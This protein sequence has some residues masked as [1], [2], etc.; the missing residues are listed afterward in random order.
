MYIV[1]D[2]DPPAYESGVISTV[3]TESADV[4]TKDGIVTL[5]W[6]KFCK[7]VCEGDFVEITDGN[8]REQ[9]GWVDVVESHSQ[10]VNII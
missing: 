1:D 6:L 7:V 9:T 10:V 3:W 5:S 4:D 2:S 8:H